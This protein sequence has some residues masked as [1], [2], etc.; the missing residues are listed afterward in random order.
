MLSSVEYEKFYNFGA[1]L[2]TVS[3]SVLLKLAAPYLL[4]LS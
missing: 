3:Y 2:Q 1:T 4:T